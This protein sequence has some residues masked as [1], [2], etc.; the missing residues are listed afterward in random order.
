MSRSSYNQLSPYWQPPPT[1]RGHSNLRNPH[2]NQNY[3]ENGTSS[4]GQQDTTTSHASSRPDTTALGNLAYASSLGQNQLQPSV[5]HIIDNNRIQGKTDYSDMSSYGVI[6]APPIFQN[7]QR[8]NS[9]GSSNASRQQTSQGQP[10]SANYQTTKRIPSHQGREYGMNEIGRSS[11]SQ[12]QYKPLQSHQQQLEAHHQNRYGPSPQPA[13]HQ[14]VERPSSTVSV[15]SNHSPPAPAAQVTASNPH[16][17]DYGPSKSVK[18]AASR[19]TN[20][21]LQTPT[22]TYAAASSYQSSK[23]DKSPYY[24]SAAQNRNNPQAENAGPVL[25]AATQKQS[26]EENGHQ[27]TPTDNQQLTTVDPNQVFNHFEYQRRQKKAEAARKAAE[28]S[29]ATATARTS[30]STQLAGQASPS[31]SS[32]VTQAAKAIMGAS[33]NAKAR[34][35]SATKE[36]IE[37]EMKQMIEKMRDYKAKDPGLFSQVWEEVKK[38]QTAQRAPSQPAAQGST[39]LP[40]TTNGQLLSPTQ[41]DLPAESDLPAASFP[42]DFDRGRYPMQRRRRGNKSYT[43]E[44]RLSHDKKH[45]GFL[46]T[47]HTQ[48]VSALDN[49]ATQISKLGTAGQ[50]TRNAIEQFK[51][52]SETSATPLLTLEPP[53]RKVW[54]AQSGMPPP[55]GT[56]YWPEH[57]KWALADAARIA[58]TSTIPNMGKMIT[59]NEIHALLDRNPSYSQMCEYLENKG[60]VIDR[61]QFARL[62]LAAVPDT[63][64]STPNGTAILQGPLPQHPPAPSNPSSAPDLPRTEPSPYRSPNG[65]TTPSAPLLSDQQQN[66]AARDHRT[67]HP[68]PSKPQEELQQGDSAATGEPAEVVPQSKQEKA[69]KRNFGEIIDLTAFSDDEE[70]IR[71]RAKPRV[72]PTKPPDHKYF[73]QFHSGASPNGSFIG[74]PR[75]GF[76]LHPPGRPN[77][78]P[79]KPLGSGREHLLYDKMVEPMNKRRDALRRSSY[80][81]RTICRD[82][83]ITSGRHPTM[84]PLNQH[85]D[86]LRERFVS[87]DNNAD[88]STFRW[89]LV[90]PGGPPPPGPVARHVVQSAEDRDVDVQNAIAAKFD[91]HQ[92]H[93]SRVAVPTVGRSVGSGR[94]DFAAQ[95]LNTKG[96]P[97]RKGRPPKNDRPINGLSTGDGQSSSKPQQRPPQDTSSSGE[98]RRE[99]AGS[100]SSPFATPLAP[101]PTSSGSEHTVVGAM[102][103]SASLR[104]PGRKGR[105]PGARNKQPRSDKGTSRNGKRP[106]EPSQSPATPSIPS[107]PKRDIS[108]PVRPSGLRN[109]MTP[110]NGISVVIPSRSPS[111]ADISSAT[112]V[113]KV[114][115]EE[116]PSGRLGFKLSYNVYK[117]HWAHCPAELHSLDTL[118]KH[119]RK[120]HRERHGD[121]PWP[122]K[123]AGCFH[124]SHSGPESH[125]SQEGET[126]ERGHDGGERRRLIF[127][128]EKSWDTHIEKRHLNE[129]AWELGDGPV[130]YQPDVESL[131]NRSGSRHQHAG[132]RAQS[133]S[134]Y[135]T[136]P[137]LD[138]D[139]KVAK[140]YHKAYEN[141]TPAERQKAYAKPITAKKKAIGGTNVYEKEPTLAT[142]SKRLILADGAKRSDEELQEVEGGDGGLGGTGSLDIKPNSDSDNDIDLPGFKGKD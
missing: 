62:L 125:F 4:A 25:P 78:D 40:T 66:F 104:V 124:P 132:S 32:D 3:G 28:A 92:R 93:H 48:S 95:P 128:L 52:T 69:K 54:N 113:K 41:A 33:A 8:V 59:S 109:V 140:D 135:L 57:K 38:G 39:T 72:D 7:H 117:C 42:Q 86:A 115:E 101:N 23:N 89:D 91:I 112:R 22:G 80:D 139:L 76:A 26:N 19:P 88:L 90:D 141:A 83:L 51:H 46:N 116:K 118:R 129:Y 10:Y 20:S 71:H 74:V 142:D 119:V 85:L 13:N 24:A 137:L 73:S 55:A 77:T 18:A 17:S 15:R 123:W 12:Q 61:G 134:N 64:S 5:S 107:H 103:S 136:D 126:N 120:Q 35:D 130:A 87:V 44:K 43:P 79:F 133:S 114:T 50:D 11:S 108:T 96:E 122:C 121:G 1:E 138:T 49:M 82:I 16:R 106:Q 84:A 94:P 65:Y 99:V 30:A 67:V 100:T 2:T 98:F 31:T 34:A 75:P 70:M 102:S 53:Q 60:F 63:S 45:T 47:E 21:T 37:L 9:H 14:V 29:K 127:G 58:L 131:E 110:T 81:P 6:S 68:A 97:R 111:I 56:T 105:P 36:Q 27:S